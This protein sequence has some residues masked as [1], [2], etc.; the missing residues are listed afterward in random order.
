M[1]PA[2][3]AAL[4]PGGDASTLTAAAAGPVLG[5]AE[6]PDLLV[7]AA[8]VARLPQAAVAA[9]ARARM[10]DLPL[11]RYVMAYCSFNSEN[12]ES[13]VGKEA[14]GTRDARET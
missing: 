7:A 1:S 13:T 14:T 6:A 12:D 10:I 4:T 11:V 5:C 3:D 9:N 2:E 8:S